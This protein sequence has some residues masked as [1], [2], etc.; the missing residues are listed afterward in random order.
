MRSLAWKARTAL[1]NALRFLSGRPPDSPDDPYNAVRAPV[2]PGPPDR[3]A[4]VALEE[5]E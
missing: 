5:P 4:A 1:Q 2:K 3:R